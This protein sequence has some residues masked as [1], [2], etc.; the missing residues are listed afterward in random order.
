MKISKTIWICLVCGIIVIAG[1]LLGTSRTQQTGQ[2][3][4]L[5]EKLAQA[6]L[7]LSQ[8]KVDELVE[9]KESLAGQISSYESKTTETLSLLTYPHDSIDTTAEILAEGKKQGV[10]IEEITSP[11]ISSEKLDG[12]TCEVLQLTLQVSGNLRNISG[13]ISGL[14]NTFPTSVIKSVQIDIAPPATKTA[15]DEDQSAATKEVAVINPTVRLNMV[16]Y[17]FKG[18]N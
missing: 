16:I 5:Q 2:Q 4:Q 12:S 18:K 7:K 9:Q 15:Y 17:N 8:I 10:D 6:N 14:S 13:F 1:I 11:G 3:Q